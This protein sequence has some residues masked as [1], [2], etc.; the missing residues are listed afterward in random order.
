VLAAR[1]A[2]AYRVIAGLTGQAEEM[3][4]RVEKLTAESTHAA[5]TT[6]ARR[7]R[8]YGSGPAFSGVTEFAAPQ[9]PLRPVA[10]GNARQQAAPAAPARTKINF[11]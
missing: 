1:L 10:T 7:P 6:S 11:G 4:A 5:R 8:R 3:A 2:E 9:G